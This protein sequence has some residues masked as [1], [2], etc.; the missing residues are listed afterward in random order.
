[1]RKT[2]LSWVTTCVSYEHDDRCVF[3]P[4][5]RVFDSDNGVGRTDA[6]RYELVP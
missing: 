5:H 3:D 6:V 1:M 2:V 4:R